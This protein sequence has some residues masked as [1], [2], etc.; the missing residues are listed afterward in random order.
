[1]KKYIL[2]YMNTVDAF[3]QNELSS[4]SIERK[5]EVLSEFLTK[6]QF[7]Q[8]ERL[9]HLIVTVLFALLEMSAVYVS[10]ISPSIASIVLSVMFLVL[11]VPYV[12]HYYFLENSVQKMYKMRDV[13]IESC[14]GLN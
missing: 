7:F 14:R 10:L 1:M 5:E 13:I 8:H 3:I 6:I 11:L 12:M 9:I 4:A 2:E